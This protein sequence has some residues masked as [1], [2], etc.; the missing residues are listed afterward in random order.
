MAK[1]TY[2]CVEMGQA[3][4]PVNEIH[5]QTRPYADPKTN[6]SCVR[7][8]AE[9]AAEAAELVGEKLSAERHAACVEQLD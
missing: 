9:S 3:S 2:Y 4:Y 7:V 6:A 1:R 5:V 8:R